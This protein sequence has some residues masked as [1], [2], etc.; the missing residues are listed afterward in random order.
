MSPL[1]TLS[2][3]T[4]EPPP[5]FTP[6][7]TKRMFVYIKSTENTAAFDDNSPIDEAIKAVKFVNIQAHICQNVVVL[8]IETLQMKSRKIS[9]N[10]P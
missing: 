1:P 3:S 10:L 2:H 4:P 9:K 8:S 7:L 5:A 6:L